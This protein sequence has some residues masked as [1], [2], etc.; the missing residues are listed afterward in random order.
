MLE[1]SRVKTAQTVFFS[2]FLS[3]S[4]RGICNIDGFKKT[5]LIFVLLYHTQKDWR[6]EQLPIFIAG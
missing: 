5:P 1:V 3:L 4:G 6:S 2:S